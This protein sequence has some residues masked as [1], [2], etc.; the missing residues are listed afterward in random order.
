M[1]WCYFDTVRHYGGR[2]KIKPK[3]HDTWHERIR[4]DL[5]YLDPK[6]KQVWH[7]KVKRSNPD[8]GYVEEVFVK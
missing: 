5:Y 6:I 8:Y 7:S 4:Q 3:H 1:E 2:H